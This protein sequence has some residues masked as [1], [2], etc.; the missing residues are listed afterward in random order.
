MDLLVPAEIVCPWC[1]DP[2]ETMIDTSQDHSSLIEDCNV[3]CRPIEL[4]LRC[5]PG[6]VLAVEI[7]RA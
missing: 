4:T 5:D 7:E 1:G 6:E 3:C 2:Y